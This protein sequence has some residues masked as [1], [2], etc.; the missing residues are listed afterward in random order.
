VASCAAALA[1]CGQG[2]DTAGLDETARASLRRQ[3]LAWLG[4]SLKAWGQRL[5][6][7]PDK[8]RPVMVQKMRHWLVDTDF[9]GVRGPDALGKLSE[10]EREPWQKLWDDVATTLARAQADTTPEKKSAAK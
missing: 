5:N 4:A 6:K 2:Q 10:A 3:S 1:G 7:E 8:V 9:A